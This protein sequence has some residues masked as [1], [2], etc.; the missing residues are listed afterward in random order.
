MESLIS[1]ISFGISV[2]VGYVGC[3]QHQ[4]QCDKR[5]DVANNATTTSSALHSLS[6]VSLEASSSSRLVRHLSTNSKWSEYSD[7]EESFI[8][9][10]PKVELHVVSELVTVKFRSF[11]AFDTNK[12]LIPF[13]CCSDIIPY[14]YANVPICCSIWMA[15]LMLNICGTI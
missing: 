10:F 11:P 12:L 3:M 1:A 2:V 14:D 8:Q 9:D 7:E 15:V 4:Q 6:S 13:L 5:N